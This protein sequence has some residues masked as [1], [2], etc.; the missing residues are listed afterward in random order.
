MKRK[1]RQYG[2][3]LT[4]SRPKLG[5]KVQLPEHIGQV[6]AFTTTSQHYEISQKSIRDSYSEIFWGI[7]SLNMV[8]EFPYRSLQVLKTLAGKH[9]APF[10]K[11]EKF[12]ESQLRLWFGKFMGILIKKASPARDDFLSISL[13]YH[14]CPSPNH[15]RPEKLTA[16]APDG[17]GLNGL[18]AVALWL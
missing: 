15:Q 11:S 18:L 5:V 13:N 3:L 8:T 7:T 4:T 14:A 16:V 1:T 17:W 2:A 6:G 12:I 9:S 10:R